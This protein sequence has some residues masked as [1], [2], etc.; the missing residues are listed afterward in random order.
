MTEVM[1]PLTWFLGSVGGV[2]AIGIAGTWSVSRIRQGDL[3]EIQRQRDK[4][5]TAIYDRMGEMAGRDDIQRLEN[6]MGKLTDSVD[7]LRR[8]I[9]ETAVDLARIRPRGEGS[10]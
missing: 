7:Q 5:L 9:H 1:V 4:D 10:A 8:E 2:L 6:G 3:T